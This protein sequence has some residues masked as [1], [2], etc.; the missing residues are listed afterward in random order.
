LVRR[1]EIMAIECRKLK[2]LVASDKERAF[3]TEKNR[4][5]VEEERLQREKEEIE[6]RAYWL[7]TEGAIHWGRLWATPL[8]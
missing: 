3:Y 8:G 2:R 1:R 4:R 5:R 6:R 7:T